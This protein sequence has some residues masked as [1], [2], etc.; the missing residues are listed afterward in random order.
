M[1]RESEAGTEYGRDNAHPILLHLR[2][3]QNQCG[4]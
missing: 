3:N 4:R 1:L 2:L